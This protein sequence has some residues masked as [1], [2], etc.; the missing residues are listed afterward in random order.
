VVIRG[1]S[2]P[3]AENTGRTS[4]TFAATIGS[5]AT[6]GVLFAFSSFVMPALDRLDPDD[7][8][9]AMNAVNVTAVR[10]AFMTVLFGTAAL[11]AV[12]TVAGIRRRGTREGRLLIIGSAVYLVGVIGLTM[13]YH[14][15]LNDALARFDPAT[16]DAPRTWSDY[17]TG[18]TRWNHVRSLA[19]VAG[20]VLLGSAALLPRDRRPVRM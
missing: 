8:I 13:A 4:L 17:S 18:W 9:R 14:V 15:P 5:A 19:G 12:T 7:A 2:R 11:T 3:A 6:G 10:P 1:L 20:A 16:G